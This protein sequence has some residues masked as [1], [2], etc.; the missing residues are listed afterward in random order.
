MTGRMSEPQTSMIGI[1]GMERCTVTFAV[2]GWTIGSFLLECEMDT[3]REKMQL[4]IGSLW[5]DVHRM[6]EDRDLTPEFRE[7]LT[8]AARLL[9]QADQALSRPFVVP[10]QSVPAAGVEVPTDAGF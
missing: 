6:A 3:L 7:A 10:Y 9:H 2:S 1:C 5:L 8:N 4:R